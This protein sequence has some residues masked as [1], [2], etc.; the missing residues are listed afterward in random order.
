MKILSVAQIREADQYT[1]QYEQIAS[2]D[3][4]ERAS[5]AFTNWFTKHYSVE[6]KVAI[7]CG[8]G[9]NGG[10]GLAVARMLHQAG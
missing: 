7:F 1:I 8:M 4:M 10:D 2:V 3:L 6:K 5:R 9:N